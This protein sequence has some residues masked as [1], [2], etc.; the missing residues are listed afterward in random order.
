MINVCWSCCSLNPQRPTLNA[1]LL[2][3]FCA[4][5]R[6]CGHDLR[7]QA[8]GVAKNKCGRPDCG[9]DRKTRAFGGA[10]W[11]VVLAAVAVVGAALWFSIQSRA[12]ARQAAAVATSSD[13]HPEPA[14]LL[15]HESELKL[16]ARQ[17]RHVQVA[18]RVWNLKR[19]AYDVQFKTYNTD[20]TAALAALSSHQTG[21]GEYGKLLVA[22]DKARAEAWEGATSTLLPDQVVTLEAVR[23]RSL[24][25]DA[26]RR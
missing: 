9:C 3:A 18:V 16:D 24:R 4:I 8:L 21:S 5:W 23:E 12:R 1:F 11:I 15:Q 13:W 17:I 2:L 6:T 22:F 20:A 10:T 7:V 19:A 25:P 26:K 14:F